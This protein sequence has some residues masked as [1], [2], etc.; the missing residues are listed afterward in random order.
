[1]ERVMFSGNETGDVELGDRTFEA[2]AATMPSGGRVAVLIDRS[3]VESLERLQEDLVASVAHEL[4]TPIAAVQGLVQ[5]LKLRASKLAPERLAM[6]LDDGEREI[7]RLERL[8]EDLLLAARVATGGIVA[9]PDAI[10]LRPIA[11]DVVGRASPRYSDRRFVV[12][13]D[14]EA[15][16]DPSL[17][18]HVIWHLVDN[19]GKFSRP[20]GTVRVRIELVKDEPQVHV[21]DEGEGIF[22]GD[23]P[24]LFRRFRQLDPSATR[25]HGG[26]GLGLF[27]T[28]AI[29][30]ALGGRVWVRSRLGQGSTFS[31]ALPPVPGDL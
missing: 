23:I 29:L 11:D 14:A 12:E 22:S 20:D 28:K 10:N 25:Q 5:L 17:V 6:L 7:A 26:A 4:R 9:V 31:V 18:R 19:A 15:H 8:V 2:A 13:G 1:M 27:L 21:T 24:K 16:A 30:D 3:N